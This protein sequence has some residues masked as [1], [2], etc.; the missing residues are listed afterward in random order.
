MTI[1]QYLQRP[2]GRLAYDTTGSHGPWV[3]CVPGM[4]E[5]RQSYRLL[6]PL[7][8]RAGCR[9]ALLDIRG[10]GDSDA[11]FDA[12]DDVAL[13]GD[14]LALIDQLGEP[15]FVVG[16]SMAAGAAVIAA[17]DAP[18][19]VRGLA[20]LG[21]FVRDPEGG[22]LQKLL[23]RVLL[24]RPWGARAFLAYYSA[25][26]PGTKPAG[27]QEHRALVAQNLRR[28]GHWKAFVQTTRTTHAPAEQRLSQVQALAVVVMGLADPDWKDPAAEAEW[29]GQQLHAR[30]VTVPDVGHFP[31][32]QAAE[33]TAAA[34]LALV[35]QAARA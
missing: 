12:Y 8:V 1:T 34:V 16:N 20:L 6:T 28:P 5:L 4:G 11:T 7:L 30:V 23:L 32:V 25:M 19:K 9:V 22:G 33:T 26:L 21:A 10:H 3:I 2:D 35:E 31:Q 18:S 24:T 29:V 13:A 14:I 27:Y 15:A 17:A